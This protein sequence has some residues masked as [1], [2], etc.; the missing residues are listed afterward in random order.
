MNNR[1]VSVIM[2]FRNAAATIQ[3]ALDSI[4]AQSFQDWEM[5]AVDDRSEDGSKAIVQAF[6]ARDSRVR[7]VRNKS[8]GLVAALNSGLDVAHGKF[9][10]RMD[11]DDYSHPQ[12]FA[13]QVEFL[14]K[15]SCIG[16][17]STLVE[18]GGDRLQSAGF[19]IHVDWLNTVVSPEEIFL[20]RFVESPFAHPSVMFRRQLVEKFGAYR[21][22]D[23][24]E[25]YELWLRWLEAGVLMAKIPRVLLTWYD[26]P[27]RLSRT[28]DRYRPDA[29]YKCKAEYLAR[30]LKTNLPT[31]RK[32]FVW[33]AGRVTRARAEFLTRHNV[34]IDG[35]IDIDPKK[36]GRS[37]QN[38]PVLSPE[39]LPP[40]HEAFILGYVS[41]RGARNLI[42]THLTSYGYL[43]GR[44]FLMAA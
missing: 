21:E 38:R 9:V 41:K 10:A 29:F 2:P 31:G 33:G 8:E 13:A 40:P 7:I 11:A 17:V 26:S 42:R 43:E 44:D 18:F 5:I 39:Q 25:D 27:G 22:G 15:N 37:H 34:R 24:P 36:Q 12:R 30:W 1:C 6:A 3:R 4:F 23:F 32:V 28:D 14:E 19:A 20:N 35:Y 16:L